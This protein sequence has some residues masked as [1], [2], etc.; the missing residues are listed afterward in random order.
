MHDSSNDS[1]NIDPYQMRYKAHQKRKASTLKEIMKSRYS[2]RIFSSRVPDIDLIKEIVND[3]K[4]KTP[5]SCD[6]RPYK[7]TLE[8][9]NDHKILLSAV[10]VGGVGWAHRCPLIMLIFLDPAA[11]KSPGEI[12][13]MPYLDSG[14]ICCNIINRLTEEGINTC[15]I[16]PNIRDINRSHFNNIFNE[17]NYIF[18]GAIA[19]GYKDY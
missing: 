6:R 5:C 11:Y 16:N 7:I 9:I 14:F 13:Y 19:I 2:E 3:C 17:K 1:L 10:L 15:F 4:E 12:N 18:C 8:T